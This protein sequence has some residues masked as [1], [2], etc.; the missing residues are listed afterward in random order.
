MRLREAREFDEMN[1]R[2]CCSAACATLGRGVRRRA[3]QG[4]ALNGIC[5][6]ADGTGSGFALLWGEETQEVFDALF[7]W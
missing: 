3:A 2:N 7:V 5:F 4:E 1:W 6:E